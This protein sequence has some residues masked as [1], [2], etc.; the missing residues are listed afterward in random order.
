MIASDI[1]NNAVGIGTTQPEALFH[2]NGNSKYKGNGWFSSK[3]EGALDVALGLGQNKNFDFPVVEIKTSDDGGT[4][5]SQWAA[6][7][8]A[9]HFSIKRQS[10]SG[11]RS[12]VNAGGDDGNHYLSLISVDGSTEAAR[13]SSNGDSFIKGSVGIDTDKTADGDFR[14]FVEK[15]IRTR[16]VKVDNNSWPDYVFLPN[17][18]LLSLKEV[19]RFID[20]NGHLPGVPS[21]AEVEK[22]GVDLGDNQA[23]LLKK[24]EELTLYILKQQKEI[25]ELKKIV[26]TR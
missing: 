24:I 16:K 12:I 13:I 3:S 18:S 2:V 7:R 4:S 23:T 19:E 25:D 22:N 6:S 20:A 11:V 17:Y 15:G 21:A 9:H 10:G 8:W 1:L 5:Y 26:S 14:L